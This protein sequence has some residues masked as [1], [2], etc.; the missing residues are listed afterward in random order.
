MKTVEWMW[1]VLQVMED[2]AR[3]KGWERLIDQINTTRNVLLSEITANRGK[4][5]PVN[6]IRV[7]FATLTQAKT[8]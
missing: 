6:V 7:N 4:G 5:I 3:K 2:D 1:E 8:H